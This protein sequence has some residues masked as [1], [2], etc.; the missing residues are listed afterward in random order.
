MAA[1]FSNNTSDTDL[2]N[3]DDDASRVTANAIVNGGSDDDILIG[4]ASFDLMHGR[5]GDD[6]LFGLGGHDSLYGGGGD[7]ILNGGG[8]DDWLS[9][10]RGMDQLKGG[11]G[12]DTFVLDVPTGDDPP[13]GPSGPD[14][15][16]DFKHGQDTIFLAHFFGDNGELPPEQFVASKSGDAVDQDDRILYDTDSGD[17][18]YDFDGSGSGAKVLLAK[19]IGHPTL[20]A[21]DF[22][23]DGWVFPF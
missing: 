9:G 3:R 5:G 15:I 13:G 21:D 16:V 22:N 11:A 8:G 12:N 2:L 10:D 4:T 19:L 20:T 23:T 7:D 6:T 14:T 1:S 17:L 18:Y